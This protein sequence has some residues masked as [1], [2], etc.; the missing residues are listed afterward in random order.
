MKRAL[1]T[2]GRLPKGLELARALHS[3]GYE[4]IIA[5]PWSW[6]L[7]RLSRSVRRSIRVHSPVADLGRYHA[8]L[9]QTIKQ[10]EVELVVPVS[11][12]VLSVSALK[13][14]PHCHARIFAE[15]LERL[16][17]LHDKLAFQQRVA[18]L[19]LPHPV[20]LD[21]RT[22]EARVF[23]EQSP[24]IA[25]PRLSSAGN[26]LRRLSR[27]DLDSL[28]ADGEPLLM[29]QMLP[30]AELSSFSIAHDGRIIG[31]VVYRGLIVSGTVSVCFERVVEPPAEIE[32]W[33]STFVSGIRHSGFISFDFR[34]DEHGQYLPMECNPRTTSGVHFVQPESL[35]S[36]INDPANADALLMRPE[37][38]LQMFYPSLTETQATALRGGDWRPLKKALFSCRDSTWQRSDPLPFALLPL[39]SWE[40]LYRTVFQGQSFGE[41]TTA[42]IGW[43]EHLAPS[44]R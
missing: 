4:V 32:R 12:E 25:K 27:G 38:R 19:G 17:L 30:G 3:I 26:G 35:G 7:S 2:L 11:E 5:E 16:S 28:P 1:I 43:Y 34:Q 39:T 44:D 20:T 8:D 10:F 23:I 33:I 21:A 29:Q 40:I 6:H 18:E 36:A 13:N 22:P 24:A 15:P 14:H 9:I 31:T 37:L 42:D 41:A